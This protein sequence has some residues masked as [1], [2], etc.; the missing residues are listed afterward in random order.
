MSGTTGSEPVLIRMVGAVTVMRSSPSP[1][2]T[3][4][5]STKRAVPVITVAVSLPS[6]PSKLPAR[7]ALV[8]ARTPATELA[9]NS[10]AS[11]SSALG[12]GVVD[13]HLGRHAADVGAGA[14]VHVLGL[15]D[16][17]D[18]LA[19]V[20]ERVR[21]G[22]AALAE[23]DDEHVGGEAGG[24]VSMPFSLS[25]LGLRPTRPFVS[26]FCSKVSHGCCQSRSSASP[27]STRS[28]DKR[29][30]LGAGDP[31]GRRGARRAQA[32]FHV[33]L[34]GTCQLAGRVAPA[35]PRAGGR[36]D[37]PQRGAA[38]DRHVR[39][40]DAPRASPRPAATRS[41]RRAASVAASR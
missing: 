41:R 1:T 40:S 24:V 2:A 16:E 28:L 29:C 25:R 27:A 19:G 26:F 10:W 13:E 7:K 15:L 5:A 17:D 37:H 9:K 8:S 35:R 22:L 3:V 11:S 36:R 34:E 33:L 12:A 20:G 31:H 23:T 14:A 18:A 39:R 30:L 6:R 38:P 4:C 21:G 32:P